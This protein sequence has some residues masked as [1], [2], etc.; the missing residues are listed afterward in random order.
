MTIVFL[1]NVVKLKGLVNKTA[2]NYCSGKVLTDECL[3]YFS[4]LQVQNSVNSQI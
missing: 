3:V 1:Y 4:V 2:L